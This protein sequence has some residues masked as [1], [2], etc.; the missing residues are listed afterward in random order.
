MLNQI[1]NSQT[2]TITFAAIL[3]FFSGLVSRA[4]GL[5]RDRL[6]AGYLGAGEELDIYFAAFRIPDFVYG[7]LIMGGVAAV[8]LPVLS[9]SFK[10]G[11]KSGWE[12]TNNVLN[13]FLVL[14]IFVC[15]ILA[16]ITPFLVKFIAPG[17]SPEAQTLT[18]SL[19]RIMFLSPILLGLSSIFSGILHYFNRFLVYGL[20]PIFYNLGIIFGIL[21]FLPVFGLPGLAYGVILGAFCHLLIQIPMA[22]ISGYSYQPFLNFKHSGLLRI[23]KLMAPRTIGAA[24][25]HLN[26]LVV[27][28]IAST[29]AAG[30][31]SIFNLSN[32]LQYFPIGL[33][34]VSF[35][36]ASFP[37][38]SRAWAE[39]NRGK[40]SE[41]FSSTFRQILFFVIPI[42]FLMFLLRAQLVRLAFG[43]GQ[44][45]WLDTRLTAA[46]LGLFCL[47][48]FAFSLI[49]LLARM[50][51]SFQNTRIPA[52][53]GVIS[54]IVNVI[55]C[56]LLV[57]LLGFSNIFRDFL[58]NLLKLQGIE[59]IQ[60]VGLALALSLSGIVQ[61]SLLFA[62]LLKKIREI[63][64]NEICDSFIKIILAGVF[65]CLAVYSTLYFVAGFVNMQT[66]FGVLYQTVS[67][68]FV[69]I[70]VY[71]FL[72]FLLKSPELRILKSAISKEF[73]KHGPSANS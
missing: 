20:A 70:L 13:C 55:L 63:N 52:V 12:L 4:L 71:L 35:A 1:L 72:S 27:T 42:S 41:N 34:G 9:E 28:A 7:I 36:L 40:F 14:L 30:S 67:A 33:I 60:V 19:A 31:I 6:L 51:Y 48:I 2:K 15:G 64:L 49:P 18:V 39:R 21:F 24:A 22:V 65:M 26:L 50:F 53:I 17:F 57:W 37:R 16:L 38:L 68:G 10:R 32:N 56:F 69:G 45:T 46:C 73:V 44:F 8:F 62:A 25:Y 3:L 47:G 29:L 23:F 11:A 43:A 5:V 54:M 66:F 59:N 61:F 58:V